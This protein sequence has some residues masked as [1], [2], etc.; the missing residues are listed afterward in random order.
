MLKILD[1]DLHKDYILELT[2][3]DGFCG[4]ADLTEY[5]SKPPFSELSDFKRFA[6]TADG[7]LSWSGNELSA[8]TLRAISVGT[9]KKPEL[10][11]NIN[12][13]EAVIKQASWESMQEGRPDIL[14]AAI[15]SYVEYFGHKDVIKRAGIKSRTSAYRSLKPETKP[16]YG[17]L[18]QLGH[19]IIE[20]A[21]DRTT[22]LH[23]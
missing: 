23:V 16:N 17:T 12:D 10:I 4:R 5:F 9:R 2:F 1:V 21:K 19:A 6:L 18:V 7:S 3:S 20:I 8:E 13:I 15:R 14:Q 11:I 22:R